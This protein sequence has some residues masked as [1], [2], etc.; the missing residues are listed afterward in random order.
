MAYIKTTWVNTTAPALNA[1]NLNKLEQG[2]EDA[3]IGFASAQTTAN[4]AQSVA[5]SAQSAASAAAA[6]AASAVATANAAGALA[7][8]VSNEVIAARGGEADLDARLDKILQPVELAIGANYALLAT[9]SGKY[10]ELTG[11]GAKTITLSD[12]RFCSY[13]YNAGTGAGT[14]TFSGAT[15]HRGPLTLAPGQGAWL[16]GSSGNIWK[17]SPEDV[18]RDRSEW[19][20]L[21]E[22]TGQTFAIDAATG[23]FSSSANIHLIHRGNNRRIRVFPLIGPFTTPALTT[24]QTLY[25]RYSTIIQR[26]FGSTYLQA[27]DL[28]TAQ[29][30]TA[31]TLPEDAI[32]LLQRNQNNYTGL[33]SEIIPIMPLVKREFAFAI[34][35][36]WNVK[37]A[38]NSWSCSIVEGVS[39]VK[40]TANQNVLIYKRVLDSADEFGRVFP[41][42]GITGIGDFELPECPP[43]SQVWVADFDFLALAGGGYLAADKYNVGTFW[44]AFGTVPDNAVVLFETGPA[45]S[46]LYGGL[47]GDLYTKF[48]AEQNKIKTL[49]PRKSY[50]G[51]SELFPNFRAAYLGKTKDLV[52]I[53]PGDSVNARTIHTRLLPL[54]DQRTLPPLAQGD[55]SFSKMARRL[56]DGWGEQKYRRFDYPSFFTETGTFVEYGSGDSVAASWGSVDW[57]DGPIVSGA[58]FRPAT[59]RTFEGTGTASV[60]F[61]IPIDAWRF[62]FIYRTS[63]NGCPFT[64]TVAAGNGV[65]QVKNA[66]GTWVEAN[67]Y[68]AGTMLESR[69]GAGYG[70]TEYQKR[71]EFRC[72]DGASF[73]SRASVKNVTISK[74]ASGSA[75]QFNYWGIEYSNAEFMLTIINAARG[76]HKLIG[77]TQNLMSYIRTDVYEKNPDLVVFEIP[78]LNMGVSDP[79][80]SNVG[81]ISDVDNYFYQTGWSDSGVPGM[82]NH[83]ANYTNYECVLKLPHFVASSFNPSTKE[84]LVAKHGSMTQIGTAIDHHR[85]VKRHI[86]TRAKQ[87]A[88]VDTC[89]ALLAASK[90][91]STAYDFIDA[92]TT[93]GTHL[94]DFGT[95]L[96]NAVE[97]PVFDFE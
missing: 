81:M 26:G 69:S 53:F 87:L 74:A 66:A 72:Y 48:T 11:S 3:H 25:V 86:Q 34:A 67:G 78:L 29:W 96:A 14:I 59:T 23:V 92:N 6:N 63:S 32:V 61:Q 40:F 2:V 58:G 43:L 95:I 82:A 50:R 5:T 75:Q 7:T 17:V 39:G 4:V 51:I 88:T 65:L 16:E 1:A 80:L 38:S 27:G 73:N 47:L 30:A 54:A 71:L 35:D 49:M 18:V 31:A 21:G 36:A 68:A 15:V 91:Y 84:W 55:N 10:L 62:N 13:L 90:G 56:L 79:T 57:D 46:N 64:V 45:G 37:P 8:L 20:L 42:N 19:T 76:A 93:D 41:N 83:S 89:E 44:T 77:G 9:D 12:I 60:A 52:V 33:L 85:A 24:G 28:L 22:V 70:N 94:N 97:E